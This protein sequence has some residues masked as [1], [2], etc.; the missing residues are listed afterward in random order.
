MGRWYPPWLKESMGRNQHLLPEIR[1]VVRGQVRMEWQP[2]EQ[3]RPIESHNKTKPKD[4]S[5]KFFFEFGTAR[6]ELTWDTFLTTTFLIGAGGAFLTTGLGLG[7]TLATGLAT[8]FTGTGLATTFFTGAALATALTGAALA[9]T[10]FAGAAA[11]FAGAALATT[12][13]TGAGAAFLTATVLAAAAFAGFLPTAKV[14]DGGVK[15]TAEL[16]RSEKTAN[17][18]VA[19]GDLYIG[20]KGNSIVCLFGGTVHCNVLVATEDRSS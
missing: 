13:L 8:A 3:F 5:A 14:I 19:R 10:F 15:A 20:Y 7:A 4:F 2:M 17:F 16:T 11:A 1:Q 6:K 18:M 12:F 9:T